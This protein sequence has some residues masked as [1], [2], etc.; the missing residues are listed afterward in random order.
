MRSALASQQASA[1]RLST[2]RRTAEGPDQQSAPSRVGDP[3]PDWDALDRPGVAAGNRSGLRLDSRS[4]ITDSIKMLSGEFE[5]RALGRLGT[6]L[7]DKYRLD[8]LLGVGG[9]A[10]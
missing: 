4:R 2:R 6:V 5:Q 3:G 8:D 9:M 10:R 7:R 1:R